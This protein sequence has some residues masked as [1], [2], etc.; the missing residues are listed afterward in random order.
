MAQLCQHHPGPV[1]GSAGRR[2]RRLFRRFKSI[3]LDNG[4]FAGLPFDEETADII[5]LPIP[6]EV[7]V[8]YSAGTAKGPQA[9]FDASFQ[10][11][12]KQL[13]LLQ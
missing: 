10:L 6:W 12:P 9:I 11:L 5:L 7:T 3:C 13:L 2:V 8:S 1:L 4:N